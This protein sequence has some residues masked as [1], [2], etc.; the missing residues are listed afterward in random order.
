MTLEERVGK[1]EED[2][3]LSN[4]ADIHRS[5]GALEHIGATEKLTERVAKLEAHLSEL[6]VMVLAVHAAI[7]DVQARV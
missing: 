4:T 3:R 7:K 6:D 1:L 5:R 2:F